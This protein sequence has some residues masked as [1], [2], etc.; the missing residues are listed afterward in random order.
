MNEFCFQEINIGLEE[1]FE[2]QI[3]EKMM[4]E[5]QKISGDCNPLH[6]DE[7]YAKNQGYEGKVVFG[8]LTA[9]FLSTLAGMYIPGENSLISEVDI[10]FHKPVYI[11]E[12]LRVIG[13]VIEKNQLYHYVVLKVIIENQKKEKVC[14][15]KMK[16]GVRK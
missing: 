11:G 4:N 10:R 16:V 5:F 9:S 7:A 14:L 12:Q 8:M 13:K 1:F 3:S 2:V 15:G 6:T